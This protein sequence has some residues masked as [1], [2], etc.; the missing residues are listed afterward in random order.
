MSVQDVLSQTEEKMQK[1]ISAVKKDFSEVSTGRANPAMVEEMKVDYYG[2]MTPIN[3][4]ASVGIPDAQTITIQ[5]WDKGALEPIEKAIMASN[6][7]ITPNSDGERIRLSVPPLSEERR[8]ELIKVAKDMAEKGKIALRNIRKEANDKIKK[9][10]S[11]SEI[12]E[13]A[14][15][16]GLDSV[17]KLIDKYTKDVDFIFEKKSKDL[18]AI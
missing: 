9:M 7:G 6:L 11:D 3:Q 13:D 4:I 18:L 14:G 8:K 2:A 16:K 1:A 12:A 17:Q 5:P 15:F 10:Q